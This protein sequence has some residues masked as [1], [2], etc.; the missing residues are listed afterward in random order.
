MSDNKNSFQPGL[1]GGGSGGGAGDF[2]G[3]YDYFPPIPTA[4]RETFY[5]TTDLQLWVAYAGQTAWTPMQNMTALSGIPPA[6]T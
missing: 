2:I 1:G 4:G 3:E 6:E 5:H